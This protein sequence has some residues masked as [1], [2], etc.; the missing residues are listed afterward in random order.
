MAADIHISAGLAS[1]VA[2]KG[3]IGN[4]VAGLAERDKVCQVVCLATPLHSKQAKRHNVMYA[5]SCFR[6]T[7]ASV[8]VSLQGFAPLGLPVRPSII[9]TTID[10]LRVV[11]SMPVRITTLARTILAATLA[12]LEPAFIDLE[13]LVAVETSA[14]AQ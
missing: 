7:L 3:S 1:C 8:V 4:T 13:S 9:I 6:T 11:Q 2:L 12:L 14:R 5:L 10:V